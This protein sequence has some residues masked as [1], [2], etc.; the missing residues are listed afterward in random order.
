MR[1]RL[2]KKYFIGIPANEIRTSSPVASM[3]DE[4]WRALVAKWS[5]P[6]NL[7]W[8]SSHFYFLIQFQVEK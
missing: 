3:T 6:K 4:Q 8:V 1:Y 2:K 7:V 5:D